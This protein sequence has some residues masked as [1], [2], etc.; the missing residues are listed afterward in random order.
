[1]QDDW[2]VRPNLTLSLGLRYEGFLN[3]YDGAGDMTAIEFASQSDNLQSDL[4][5]A[6]IVDMRKYRGR[7]AVGWR[8][9]T[10]RRD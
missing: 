5:T 3:I 9:H 8:Q 2:K 4:A 10:S 7:R 6:R 1:M